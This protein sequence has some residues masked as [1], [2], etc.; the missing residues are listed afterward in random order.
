MFPA[1]EW[2][3]RP[4]LRYLCGSY[5]QQLATRDTRRMRQILESR[6]YQTR[7]PVTLRRDQN[8]KTRFDNDQGGWRLGTSVGGRGTVP[9]ARLLV[10]YP[11]GPREGGN[12]ITGNVHGAIYPAE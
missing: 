6:W 2:T 10:P 12:W 5:D 7:W 8:T 11:S 3:R 1:W 9:S 4:E